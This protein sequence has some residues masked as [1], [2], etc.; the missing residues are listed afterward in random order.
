MKLSTFGQRIKHARLSAGL[1]QLE[2][3]N[4]IS[5]RTGSKTKKGLVSQ[6]ENGKIE[7][8]QNATILAVQE[9][10]GFAVNWLV[11]GKGQD[12]AKT[13]VL[14]VTASLRRIVIIA[15]GQQTT[16]E[17][18]A[19]AVIELAETLADDP[20]ISDAVLKRIARLAK[21]TSN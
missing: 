10:T 12:R 6:W 17:A 11:S 8:P 18:I 19:D 15:A 1:T 20:D 2:L 3:A 4:A 9:A 21:P 14:P 16:P 7:N 5:V 13:D